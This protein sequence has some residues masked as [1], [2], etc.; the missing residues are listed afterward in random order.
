[1]EPVGGRSSII[2]G[3]A[4][5]RLKML[6]FKTEVNL[7]E[8]LDEK[9]ID[10]SAETLAKQSLIDHS[11]DLTT[12]PR[13]SAFDENDAVSVVRSAHSSARIPER[14]ILSVMSEKNARLH[15]TLEVEEGME[16]KNPAEELRKLPKVVGN[17]HVWETL[18]EAQRQ[19][20]FES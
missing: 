17:K 1:M 19:S 9:E 8:P 10:M 4:H 15:H 14:R 12:A 13:I 18:S 3:K 6:S 11:H 7:P 20:L 2:R 16:V 5:E